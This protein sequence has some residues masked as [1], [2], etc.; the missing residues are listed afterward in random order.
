MKS[1]NTIN[2][3]NLPQFLFTWDDIKKAREKQTDKTVV[4]LAIINDSTEVGHE[5]LDALESQGAEYFLWSQRHEK[6]NMIK[7]RDVA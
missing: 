5:F 7:L 3:A 4:G 6:E 2:K 1:F